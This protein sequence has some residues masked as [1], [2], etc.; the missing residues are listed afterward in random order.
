MGIARLFKGGLVT[1]ADVE[2][3]FAELRHLRDLQLRRLKEA[4]FG[5]MSE[6]EKNEYDSCQ[7]R[8]EE[9]TQALNIAPSTS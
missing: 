7:K 4:A 2:T 8:I 6:A 9:I 5:G 3:L 1:R